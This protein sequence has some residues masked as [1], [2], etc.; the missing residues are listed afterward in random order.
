MH[1]SLLPVLSDLIILHFVRSES[2]EVFEEIF[3]GLKGHHKC[4]RNQHYRPFVGD[5]DVGKRLEHRH[6][7]VVHV[8][9]VRKLLKEV[10][11]EETQERVFVGSDSVLS[12][13][14]TSPDQ[15]LLPHSGHRGSSLEN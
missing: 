11:G 8:D 12:L 14:R 10:L 7:N 1:L 9:E 4:E 2:L 6:E 13:R 15:Q 3:N 5:A